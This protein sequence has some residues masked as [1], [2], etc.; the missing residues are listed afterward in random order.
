MWLWLAG[1]AITCHIGID[2]DCN[3]SWRSNMAEIAALR[4]T[5]S[6]LELRFRWFSYSSEHSCEMGEVIRLT[7]PQ[8]RSLTQPLLDTLHFL[9]HPASLFSRAV[10]FDDDPGLGFGGVDLLRSQF[11]T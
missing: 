5:V 8:P 11:R 2:S 6:P 9:L 7:R 10:L 4:S 3:R 1:I